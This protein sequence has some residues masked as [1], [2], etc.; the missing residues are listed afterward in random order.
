M[1]KFLAMREEVLNFIQQKSFP[2][3]MAKAVAQSGYL[4]VHEAKD[5]ESAGSLSLIQN[6]LYDFI[7][8]FRANQD[9]FSSFILILNDPNLRKFSHFGIKFYQFLKLLNQ[10]DKLLYPPDPR[11]AMAVNDNNFSYSIKSEAFFL[12]ALHPESP[13]WSRRFKYPAIV[14]NPHVQFEKL[15]E[16]KL[17]EKIKKAIRLRD[18]L[19][20]GSVNPMLND[21]G[22]RSE[23]FQYLGKSYGPHDPIPL[24]I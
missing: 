11:V 23:V 6:Q 24:Q 3:I 5:L 13:R 18:K 15:R 20:Q 8:H 2:C 21:F 10:K 19:L 12:V 16:K 1:L 17:F 9:K 22:E 7:D 4:D 14:F